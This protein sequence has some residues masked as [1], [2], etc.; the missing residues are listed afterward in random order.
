MKQDENDNKR[1]GYVS[2]LLDRDLLSGMLSQCKCRLVDMV[3][4]RCKQLKLQNPTLVNNEFYERVEEIRV[5]KTLIKIFITI[6][7]ASIVFTAMT[8]IAS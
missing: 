7:I 2:N 1:Q 8:V 5:Q 3:E 6:A 4:G